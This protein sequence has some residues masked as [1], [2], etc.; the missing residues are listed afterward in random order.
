MKRLN[1]KTGQP[2]KNGDMREDGLFFTGYSKRIVKK[3]GY[4]EEKWTIDLNKTAMRV[5]LGNYKFTAKK[6]NVPF[7]LTIEYLESI[8][9]DVCP[10][11][12]TPFEWQRYG[13]GGKTDQ[14]PT[15]DRIIPEFGYIEGNVV[16]ISDLANRIKSNVT[17]TELYAVAD[18]LHDKRKEVL[19]AIKRQAAQL[20]KNHH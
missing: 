5:R 18:W 10:I 13:L 19:N 7:N 15:L 4:V 14:S 17:E 6:Q 2:F 16:W 3:T 1:P 11:F 9:T 20:S 12:K 8:K